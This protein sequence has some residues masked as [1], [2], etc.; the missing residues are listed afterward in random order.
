MTHGP[1]KG[2]L[3]ECRAGPVGCD[4]LMRAASRA[5]PLLYCFGHIH[6][7]NGAEVV[8]WKDDGEKLGPEAIGQRTSKEN[9]Y[10]KE[11]K[12]PL[13]F[14]EDTLMVNAAI[15]NLQYRPMNA[16]WIVDLDLPKA[17]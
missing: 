17:N 10:P 1:P 7:G 2:I 11:N 3:D 12:I 15:M 13:K 9:R 5:R 6:E 4:A 14:G 8:K 16:P